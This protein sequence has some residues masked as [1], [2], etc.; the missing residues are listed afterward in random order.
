MSGE[1]RALATLVVREENEACGV[2]T[3]EQDDA[4]SRRAVTT[5][6]RERHRGRFGKLRRNGLLQ[7]GLELAQR[8]GI[9]VGFG[10][11]S[12]LIFAAQVGDV[13]SG[14]HLCPAALSPGAPFAPRGGPAGLV[15]VRRRYYRRFANF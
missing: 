13:Q 7:P 14:G 5:D 2:R 4:H 8:V 6:R 3:L 10:E 15:R 11:R 12:A 9:D 1:L